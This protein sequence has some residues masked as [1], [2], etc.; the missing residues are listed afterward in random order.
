MGNQ[1]DKRYLSLQYWKKVHEKN[2]YEFQSL[3][4]VIMEK[5]NSEFQRV[6]PYGKLGDGGN[7]GYIPSVGVYCQIY[8]PE[9]PSDKVLRQ[10]RRW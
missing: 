10:Q 4:S 7:D 6:R 2:G 5:A 8:A 9:N 3:F 1:I